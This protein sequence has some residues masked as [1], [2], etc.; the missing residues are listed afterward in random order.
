MAARKSEMRYTAFERDPDGAYRVGAC[1]PWTVA[2]IVVGMVLVVALLV[3]VIPPL[4]WPIIGGGSSL[5]SL[6]RWL[7]RQFPT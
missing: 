5:L 2:I 7:M 4:T 3:G 1:I 6:I